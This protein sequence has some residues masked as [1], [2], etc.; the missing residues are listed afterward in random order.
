[1][2]DE[3]EKQE[4]IIVKRVSG[5]G[6]GHHGGAW[7]IAFA[8]F[9]TAMMALFLVLWLVNAANEKTKKSIASY[10]NPVKLVDRTRSTRGLEE[11]DPNLPPTQRDT[12]EQNGSPTAATSPESSDQIAKDEVFFKDPFKVMEQMANERMAESGAGEPEIEERFVQAAVVEDAFL[13]PF[14]QSVDAP[15]DADTNVEPDGEKEPKSTEP[16]KEHKFVRASARREVPDVP[17]DASEKASEPQPAADENEK[18]GEPET[19]EISKTQTAEALSEKIL[20]DIQERLDKTLGEARQISESLTV[21]ATAEGVLISIT[22]QLG[23]SMFEVGSA[24]PVGETVVALGEISK[25]LNER[26][27]AVRIYG[28]TDARGT[29][30]GYDNWR[31]STARA[32]SA[33]LMLSRG[34]LETGRLSQVVGFAA[35][36]LRVPA[37]PN[38]DANRRI[39]ILLEVS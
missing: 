28:H 31:L 19:D 36:K 34:G 5:G 24:V 29:D 32:H 35:Q 30:S 1:M 17:A 37:D 10:F 4:I 15:D 11:S 20:D 16:E 21:E 3:E 13:D 18:T 14:S 27:G 33:R 23:F 8:D 39:E 38:A 26:K 9:M 25:V 6:D 12:D 22:D 2:A 7:K